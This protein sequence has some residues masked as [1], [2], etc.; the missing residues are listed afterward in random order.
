MG[1]FPKP[2]QFSISMILLITKL[3]PAQMTGTLMFWKS[4]YVFLTTG[5]FP[6]SV[7]IMHVSVTYFTYVKHKYFKNVK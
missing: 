4:T 7:T 2:I 3:L 5:F 6:L 1:S